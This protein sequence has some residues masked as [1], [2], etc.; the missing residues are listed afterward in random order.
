[1]M[2]ASGSASSW[3]LLAILLISCIPISYP[4]QTYRRMDLAPSIDVSRRGLSIAFLTASSILLSPVP[5]PTPMWA[6]PLPSMIVLTSAKS[7]LTIPYSEMRSEMP[8][9][10]CLSTSSAIENASSIV[11]FFSLESIS[12]SLGIITRESTKFVRYWIP[13]VA[14]FQRFLPSNENGLVTTATVSAPQSIAA[15][16]M[17]G[18]APVPVPPPIPAVTNTISASCRYPE[19]SSR[20]SSAAFCPI[21]GLAP[22][23][24]PPVSFSPI[25]IFTSALHFARACLSVLTAIKVTPWRFSSTILLMA[26]QPPPPTPTTLIIAALSVLDTKSETNSI[27]KPL[28]LSTKSN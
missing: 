11:V 16:A 24:R 4:P 5:R 13:F 26:L 23:P 1:M 19:I 9:T 14:L 6:T 3:I 17:I 12:L 10:P 8:W 2:F 20:V 25:W 18:A 28:L 7:T 15:L 22:A 21:S 27:I